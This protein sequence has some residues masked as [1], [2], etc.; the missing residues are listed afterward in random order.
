LKNKIGIIETI[1]GLAALSVCLFHFSKT[2]I[3]FVGSSSFFK[4]I[5]SYGWTGVEAFFVVSG[6][7]IP[8]SLFKN[9]YKSANFLKFLEKRCI[10]IEPVYLICIIAVI[11]LNYICWLTPGFNGLKPELNLSSLFYH[12]FYLPE[13]MGY[14]WILPVFW[15]LEIE[16]HY[17]LIMGLLFAFFWKD[18]QKFMISIS[19]LLILSFI[20]PLKIFQYMPYFT[21]GILVCSGK[22]GMMKS[23]V[24][25]TGILISAMA[26]ILNSETY[27][28]VF[29]GIVT[30]IGIHY[31]NFT[32]RI[33]NFLGKI[34]YSLYL[35]HI[36][37]GSRIL[38][39]AGR[40]C[41]K[42]YETW[43]AIIF[44]LIF[45]IFTAWIFYI[46]IEKPFQQMSK[47]LSYR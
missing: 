21:M 5:T 28:P 32:N 46:L 14:Q 15:T 12:I 40:Y 31:F 17:Y 9:N 35:I 3:Q 13:H 29:V 26:L 1:R 39:I 18:T 44:A 42:S 22:T 16:F 8:Y 47:K 43:F 23:K 24:I 10:R 38:N 27:V 41:H 11:V 34:S 7:I 36:P 6:F 2:N 4:T 20:I 45:T 37:I 25:I 19:I 30:A 33:T